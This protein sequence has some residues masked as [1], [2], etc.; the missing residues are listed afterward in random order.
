MSAE[1]GID[2]MNGRSGNVPMTAYSGH[3][4]VI[5][6]EDDDLLVGDLLFI[7]PSHVTCVHSVGSG[8]DN[9]IDGSEDDRIIS[10]GGADD[11]SGLWK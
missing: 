4:V 9:I 6:I 8:D 3:H 10:C 7:L 5:G 2:R 1:V 11:L